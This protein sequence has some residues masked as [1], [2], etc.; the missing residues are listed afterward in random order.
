MATMDPQVD[1]NQMNNAK[2]GDLFEW[3]NPSDPRFRWLQ[4]CLA[5]NNDKDHKQTVILE[6]AEA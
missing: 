5:T 6:L 1:Q 4:F 3:K 2:S